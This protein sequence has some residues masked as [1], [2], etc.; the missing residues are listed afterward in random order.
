MTLRSPV[1]ALLWENW[2][3]TRVE[4][5]WRLAVGLVVTLGWLAAVLPTEGARDIG[6]TVALAVMAM[7]TGLIWLSIA[8][9][10]GGRMLDGYRPGFPLYLLYTRPVR[11]AVLVSVSMAFQ[12]ALAAA[13]YLVLALVLRW[14]FDYPFPLLPVAA[15]IAAVHL[16]QA[17]GDW[18]TRSK[19]VQWVGTGG[20]ALAFFALAR[21]RWEGSPALF[22]L[23]LADYALMAAISLASFGLAIA[24]V[25]RQRRGDAWA[26]MPRTAASAGF[27][28]L[29][30][31]LFRFPCPTSSATRAQVWFELKSSGLPV[32]AIGLALAIL[33]PL[34]FAVSISLPFVRSFAP[35]CA[36]LSVPAVLILGG[37]AFGIRRRQGRTYA[38]AF[39]ATQPYDTAR[40]AGLKVLVRTACVLTALL[41]VGASVWA[42]S[43]LASRWGE[44]R[45]VR[46]TIQ[47]AV[48]GL[49]GYQLAALAVVACSGVAIMVAFRAALVALR[50]RYPRHVNVAGSVLLIN[51]FVLVLLVLAEQSGIA[52]TFVLYAVQNLT[53]GVIAVVG[54]ASVLATAYLLWRVLAERLLTLRQVSGAV[55]ISAVFG[56]AWVLLL[57]AAGAPLAGMP[58]TDAA[59]MLS[60]ALLPLTATVLATWSLS[61]IRHT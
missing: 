17:A 45:Q 4:A 20:P 31:G 54:A 29:L 52:S 15:A 30:V 10:K 60:P 8:K 41:A 32:L 28:E 18:S 12:A 6:A 26:A 53:N 42:S 21:D 34:V 23:S 9:I 24:G 3:L 51:V 25:A 57:R 43:S 14:T 19:V 13:V 36:V 27:P 1:H 7:V 49:T 39:E 2:R 48:G 11:T 38:S 40:L 59:S 35:V 22:N 47:G 5:A 44:M 58:M 33:N 37:N 55:L 16:A 61:R 50:A 46:Q 56:A